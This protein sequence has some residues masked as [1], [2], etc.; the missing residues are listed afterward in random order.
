MPMHFDEIRDNWN[1]REFENIVKEYNPVE[2]SDY[3]PIGHLKDGSVDYTEFVNRALKLNSSVIFPDFPI[4]INHTGCKLKSNQNLIFRKE[5][6]LILSPNNKKAY[7]ILDLKN[8]E[9][10]NI[11][12]PSLQGDRFQHSGAGEW[13]MGIS[14][15]SAKNILIS[16]PTIRDCWGDGI[17][18]G[19]YNGGNSSQNIQIKNGVIDRNRRNGI[20]VINIDG[21]NIQGTLIK[22]TYGIAPQSAIQ[23]EPNNNNDKLKNIKIK[24]VITVD[25]KF[26]G[27]FIN[28]TRLQGAVDS[29]GIE[30]FDFKNYN[31]KFGIGYVS[32]DKISTKGL[33]GVLGIDGFVNTNSTQA[34]HSSKIANNDIVQI[35]IK[36]SDSVT[37]QSVS[38]LESIENLRINTN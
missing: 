12:N 14:I 34:F 22:N 35:H 31:S 29:I 2:V 11:F 25:N 23:I 37:L 27:I 21:L 32:L 5:S 17:Y 18:V 13:G 9:N 1:N 33:K 24:D 4:L 10:V 20:S 8:I 15:K 26:A 7:A 30:I 3:L 16:N 19:T 36:V 6:L 38:A 28:T